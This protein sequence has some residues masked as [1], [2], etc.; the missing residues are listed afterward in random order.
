[1]PKI[2]QFLRLATVACFSVSLR[3][4]GPSPALSCVI[5]NTC[6]NDGFPTVQWHQAVDYAV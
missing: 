1:M 6:G 5:K 2:Q 4:I 3:E